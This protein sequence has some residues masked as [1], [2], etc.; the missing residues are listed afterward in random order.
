[1]KETRVQTDVGN[2][3]EALNVISKGRMV[4]DWNEVTSGTNPYVVTK[5]SNIPGKSVIEIPGLIFGDKRKPVS[6]IGVGMTLTESVIELASAM[7][8]DLIIV[9]HPVADAASS[10]GVPFADYL[11]LYNLSLIEMHEA[12]HGLHPGLTLLHGHTKLTTDIAFGGIPGNVLHKGVALPEVHTAGDVLDR[13]DRFMGR[14]IDQDMLEAERAIRGEST[15]QEATIS[16]PAKLLSGTPD[17]PVKHFLHFFPHTGFSMKHLETALQM[18]PETD[19]IIASI[20]RVREDHEFVRL[21]KHRGLNF[22][23]GNSHSVEIMENGLPLAYA[24]EMLLPQV[25]VFL[26]RERITAVALKDVGHSQ[27]VKYG[28]EMAEMHLVSKPPQ[29]VQLL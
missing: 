28:K 10:G 25:E 13:I 5:T 8:L 16:N 14:E 23:V 19:T 17:S 21:A 9:H 12:F 22:I 3:L 2:V 6:R 18:Y 24:L 29:A 11:P 7:R 20:S 27:M 15:L 26:L 1:M 4:M